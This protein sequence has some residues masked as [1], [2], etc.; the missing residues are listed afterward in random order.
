MA[1]EV[2][3]EGE[4]AAT[5]EHVIYSWREVTNMISIFNRKKAGEVTLKCPRCSIAMDKISKGDVVIDICPSCRGM[6]L[7]DREIDK[8]VEISKQN[9]GE[10]HDR[11]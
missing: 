7:D 3:E 5:G 4:Q 6:W 10:K 8:L 1:A 2:S 11:K 9:K